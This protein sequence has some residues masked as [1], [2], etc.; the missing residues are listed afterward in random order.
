[1]D[2]GKLV[3]PKKTCISF[4]PS[5]P[6]VLPFIGVIHWFFSGWGCIS[7]WCLTSWV[8]LY[9]KFVICFTQIQISIAET[10]ILSPCKGLLRGNL[11][12]LSRST[13][14]LVAMSRGC[15]VTSLT[16]DCDTDS[17]SGNES[18]ATFATG[19][20]VFFS[21]FDWESVVTTLPCCTAFTIEPKNWK[22]CWP[23]AF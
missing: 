11:G 1:M 19:Y 7:C 15:T 5:M 12:L 2:P 20:H 3:I 17:W 4:I 21:W 6:A 10:I 23:S 22:P 9:M 16:W 18:V 8:K 13:L 14:L